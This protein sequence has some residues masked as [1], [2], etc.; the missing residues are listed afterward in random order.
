[1]T[2]IYSSI[3]LIISFLSTYA[4]NQQ[5]DTLHLMFIGDIMSHGP[6][7]MSAFNQDLKVYDYSEN[8]KYVKSIFNQ[9]DVVIGN[10]ETTLGVKPYS[11]YPQFSAP[12]ALATACK[13]AGID[14]LVTANNHSCDKGLKGVLNTIKVLDSL[15]I[16]HLG[17][18]KNQL[19]RGRNIP[20]IIDKNSIKLAIL[21]YTYGT[22]GIKTPYPSKVNLIDKKAIKNDIDK[23]LQARPDG[24]LTF[25]HWG[26]QYQPKAN[27]KQKT[28]VQF[29][30][31]NN[32]PLVI[33]SHPHVIQE[34]TLE[35]KNNQ[36][37]FTVYSL[38]NFIS[39]QRKFPR[40]GSMIVSLKLIKNKEG[41]LKV[42][43]YELIPTW[44]YK[45]KTGAKWYYEILPVEDF[46]FRPDYFIRNEDYQK[47]MH[48]YKHFLQYQ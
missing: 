48:Y 16:Q 36:D 6:Q 35:H 24:I 32:V 40:V 19:E 2:K 27:Q 31:Q 44:V 5:T 39:N 3:L 4:Q 23:T 37:Y 1:M 7:L 9:A 41:Q 12:P 15:A 8:F 38:G 13:Q 46:K 42:V 22:N 17:T 21:N 25:L 28:L 47:M 30:N 34:V 10:L 18:Y 26:E 14:I 11:G 43:H 33:G 45:Y 20:F 29:L